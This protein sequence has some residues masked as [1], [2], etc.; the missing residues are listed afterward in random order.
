M[1]SGVR[2]TMSPAINTVRIINTTIPYNPAPTPPKIISP[3][4]RFNIAIIPAMGDKLSCI[5]LTEPFD[6]ADVEVAQ[7]ILLVMPK[8]V[9]L[10]S[11]KCKLPKMG[12]VAYSAY[13]EMPNPTT[14][15]ISMA[16][17]I[18]QPCREEPTIFP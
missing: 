15:M 6:A 10:P 2:P 14:S 9:S 7:S 3:S 17:K 16:E 5:A 8:R 13:K 12:L 1:Y 11:I 4:I 18:A